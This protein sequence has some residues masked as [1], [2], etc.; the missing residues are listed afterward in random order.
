MRQLENFAGVMNFVIFPMFF[1]SSALYPLWRV[2]EASLTLYY[3]C[4]INP[5]THATELIRF[6]LYDQFDAISAGVV[7]AF[8]AVFLVLAIQGYDPARG[9]IARHAANLGHKRGH[10]DAGFAGGRGDPLDPEVLDVRRFR[11]RL[12]D[13]LRHQA[14]L[15]FSPRQCGL[16]VEH[17]L[18]LRHVGKERTHLGRSPQRAVNFR[19][20]WMN[21]HR[22]CPRAC[23]RIVL[24]VEE[25]GLA[26]ALQHNIEVQDALG[27]VGVRDTRD[28]RGAAIGGQPAQQRIGLVERLAGKINPR[29]EPL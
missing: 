28:Q 15:C 8:L 6:A 10:R 12:G 21:A 14:E 19:I 23:E 25:H 4:Q 7:L 22:F 2:Q 27:G 24:Y 29:N 3:V 5:F 1:A 26:A 9:L 13:L 18:K 20:R 11:N 16:D 17:Q